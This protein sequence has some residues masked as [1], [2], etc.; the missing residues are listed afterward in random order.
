VRFFTNRREEWAIDSFAPYKSPGMDK[1]FPVLLQEG[2]RIIVPFLVKIFYSC[3]AAGYV[4]A[5]WLWFYT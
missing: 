3:L 5:I 1:I 4:P 2:W